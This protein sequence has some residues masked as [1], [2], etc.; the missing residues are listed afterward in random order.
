MRVGQMDQDRGALGHDL[1]GGKNQRRHLPH[2]IDGLDTLARGF[3][4]PGDAFDQ[5]V[6]DAKQ[7][8]R[9]LDR[10]RARPHRAE[11]GEPGHR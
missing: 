2:R 7:R 9:R 4:H 10:D 8:Q 5:L 3:I 6:G 11:D 1:A